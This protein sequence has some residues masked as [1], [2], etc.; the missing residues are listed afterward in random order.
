MMTGYLALLLFHVLF[1]NGDEPAL[2]ELDKARR[3]AR[4]VVKHGLEILRDAT[5]EVP[6]LQNRLAQHLSVL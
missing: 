5:E 1:D 2:A 3:A 6:E 4:P